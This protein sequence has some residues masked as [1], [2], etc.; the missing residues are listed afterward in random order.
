MVPA[1]PRVSSPLVTG[2]GH[3]RC[4]SQ[5]SRGCASVQM[6][7][8]RE[9]PSCDRA[10]SQ[11]GCP[12]ARNDRVAHVRSGRAACELPSCDRVR[13]QGDCPRARNERVAHVRSSGAP[14]VL[15]ERGTGAAHANTLAAASRKPLGRVPSERSPVGSQLA[16]LFR[17]CVAVVLGHISKCHGVAQVYSMHRRFYP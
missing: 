15:P 7:S 14:K 17:R 3:R 5:E 4:L 2:P 1:A 16:K 13:P 6:G 8:T 11:G 9:L 10:Q 12:T